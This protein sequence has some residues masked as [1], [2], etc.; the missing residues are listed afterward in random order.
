MVNSNYRNVAFATLFVGVALLL[1]GLF[2]GGFKSVTWSGFIGAGIALT[3]HG[4]LVAIG[5][6]LTLPRKQPTSAK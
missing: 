2:M 4:G 5:S 6:I 1:L 3:F